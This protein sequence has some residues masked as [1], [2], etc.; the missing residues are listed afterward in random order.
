M[1]GTPTGGAN[2]MIMNGHM[3]SLEMDISNNLM[4]W[5]PSDLDGETDFEGSFTINGVSSSHAHQC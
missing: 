4:P 2:G 5:D 3:Q 1:S